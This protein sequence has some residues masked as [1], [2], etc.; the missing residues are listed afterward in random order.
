[1]HKPF[2]KWAGGKTKIVKNI[3]D[4]L[5]N[6]KRLV[7]PFVGSAAVFLNANFDN[8]LLADSNKDIINL[9]LSLRDKGRSFVSLCRD[10]FKPDNNYEEIFMSLR[11]EFNGSKD[12]IIRSAIFVYLN[13]HCFNG[14]CRYN[15]KGEF[16]VPFG[17]Y[18]NP[19]H[20]PEKEM[21]YFV[22]KCRGK[23]VELFQSDFRST[24]KKIRD[25]DVIYADPPY[26]PLSKT[27]NFTSYDS[28]GFRDQDQ[29]DLAEIASS[30]KNPIVISN[31]D[32]EYTRKMYNKANHIENTRGQIC[33]GRQKTSYGNTC[34]F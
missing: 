20:F 29:K 25:G 11:N 24:L 5:P 27:S 32:T 34:S 18:K 6:G 31:H 3:L 10:Y 7:E 17:S 4:I 8:Y 30:I 15:F 21:L 13:R 2:L 22:E 14:L 16:N 1:M 9:Y 33:W 26:A 23:N 28:D 19:V 12:I